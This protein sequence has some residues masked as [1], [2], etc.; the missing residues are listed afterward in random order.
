[1]SLSRRS[2]F[3]RIGAAGAVGAVGLASGSAA[4]RE[5]QQAGPDDVGMLYDSTLCIGCRACVTKCKEVS[6]LPVDRELLGGAPYDAPRDLSETTKNIIKLYENGDT[7]A[8]MKMQCM[9]CIDPACVSVCMAGA[10][11]KT[12]NG[13]VAYDK[14]VCVGC[15]YCQ[16]ACPFDVP[17]FNWLEAFPL[18]IKCEMCRHREEGPA[19]AEFCPRG[20]VKYGKLVDLLETAHARLEESPDRYEPDVYGEDDG[21]GTH[22][23]YLS[24][25]G[26][27]FNDLGL[28]E[29]PEEPLPHMSES[30]QHTIYAGF[31]APAALYGLLMFAQ[32]RNRKKNAAEKGETS[33]GRKGGDK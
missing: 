24:P 27:T 4:A 17:K 10:L 3:K 12:D 11:H 6:G 9:H 8:F 21:G 2:F 31:A 25:K 26:V 13:I 5:R 22:V 1:M 16:V 15:R 30:V 20:A 18:I 19:C 28:P 23:L 32:F 14:D 33:S 29:L 7:R